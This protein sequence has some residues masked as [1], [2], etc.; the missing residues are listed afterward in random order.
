MLLLVPSIVIVFVE[1]CTMYRDDA[2]SEEFLSYDV[3]RALRR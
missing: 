1:W 3:S 2:T